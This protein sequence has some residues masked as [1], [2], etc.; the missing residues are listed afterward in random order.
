ML[1]VNALDPR[2]YVITAI[3]LASVARSAMLVPT[4]RATRVGP[5]VV[6]RDE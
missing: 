1:G 3:L 4:R 2:A 6:L 5:L